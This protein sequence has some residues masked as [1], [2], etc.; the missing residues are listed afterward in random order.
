MSVNQN[1]V[2][3][4]VGVLLVNDKKEI[5]L[6]RSPKWKNSWAIIGGG[7]EFGESFEECGTREVK[8]E[9]NLDVTNL[10]F[11]HIQESILSPDFEG[12]KH[13]IFIN[14]IGETVE[15]QVILNDEL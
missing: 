3:A 4:V 5:F 12:K 11:L 14:F 1:Q 9:T 13:F 2:R 10:S 15:T 7:I 8:E 6:A